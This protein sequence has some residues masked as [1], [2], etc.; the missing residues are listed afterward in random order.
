MQALDI[1]DQGLRYFS[2]WIVNRDGKNW[3]FHRPSYILGQKG[4]VWVTVNE[5]Y[6]MYE[7]VP[8]LKTIVDRKANMFANMCIR[9]VDGEGNDVETKKTKDLFRLLD[10]PHCLY[11]QKDFLRQFKI[12]EQIY[13]NQYIYKNVV[14]NLADFPIALANISG[15]YM[16]PYLT[17]KIFDQVDISGVIEKYLLI[18]HL[19]QVEFDPTTILYSRLE[20]VDSPIVG[21]SPIVS[22]QKPLSNILLAYEYRNVIMGQRGAVGMITNKGKDAAGSIPLT[23]EQK[24]QVEGDYRKNYGVQ[25]HKMKTMFLDFDADYI[26]MSY[27]TRDMQLLEEVQEDTLTVIDAFGL[28]GNIF[29]VKDATYENLKQGLIHS[30]QDTIIP[31]AQKFMTN[32]TE[33]LN[34]KKIFGD[35]VR[36]M[37]DYSHLSIL[38]DDEV[39][40]S[41]ALKTKVDALVSAINAGIITQQEARK[42]SQGDFDLPI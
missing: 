24:K 8:Q 3:F 30:Y 17:G 20:D 27:P 2:D 4:P 22:L 9:L 42:A 10:K 15:R 41:S 1:I 5:P 26:P 12:Q 14:S 37:A 36:L 23:A 38:Q 29:A 16:R 32:L 35:E 13:G 34:I 33:F 18:T 25:G 6:Q 28:S 7:Q 11:G 40:R 19:E 21:R 31:E 39:Q